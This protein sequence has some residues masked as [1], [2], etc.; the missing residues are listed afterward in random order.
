MDAQ[1]ELFQALGDP[2]RLRLVNLLTQTG[3]ICVCELVDALELP[4]YNVSRHLQILLKAGWL[5]DRK[6]GKWVYYR[7]AR[8]L[9]PYHRSLLRAIDQLR[10]EREDFRR[11]EQR[12]SRRLK[13]RRGGLCCVGLVP[14]SEIGHAAQRPDAAG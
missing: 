14:S 6:V 1:V 2:T 3:E 9:K 11:D 7:V 5:E 13:L 10:E 12:A 8:D 4:Q